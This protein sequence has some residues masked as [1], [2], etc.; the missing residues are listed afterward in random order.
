M[1]DNCDNSPTIT[2]SPAATTIITGS[3]EITIT[4]EDD[5]GNAASCTFFVNPNDVV[6]PTITCPV[7]QNVNVNSICQFT[8]PDYTGA[9][10]NDDC[11]PAP[12]VTQVP[13]IGSI[14]TAATTV[15]LTVTDASG[16]SD[17]CTF[18]AIP[19]DATAPVITC[20]GNQLEA[21]D[22][23]CEFDLINYTSLPTVNDNCD[24]SPVVTQSPAVGF[25]IT[26]SQVVTLTATDANGNASS[27]TF[28]VIPDDTTDPVVTCP[29]D[30]PVSF[31]AQCLYNII[32]YT[33]SAT[34]TDNCDNSLTL[35]QSPVAGTSV[36]TTTIVEI[37]AT[38]DDGNS[39]SCTF[40]VI[41][42]DN[43][44]P[45]I[46][47]PGDQVVN[48]NAS[49]QYTLLNYTSSV[50]TNDNCDNTPTVTQSP[51][52][53]S[54]ITGATTITMTSTDD[55]GNAASC[56]FQV[57]PQDVTNPTISCGPNLTPSFNG[58]CQFTLGNYLGTVTA[59]DN[60]DNS[61][62]ITQ[63]PTLG[64]VVTGATTV[65]MTATDDNS[66][67]ASCTFSINPVDGQ[68]PSV[69]CPPT[70]NVSYS[71][72]CDFTLAD[73]TG[74][75]TISDN[76]DLTPTVTQSPSFGTVITN[77]QIVTITAVDDAGNSNNCTFSVI[78]AD[79]TLPTIT[80]PATQNVSFSA[81]C[82]FTLPNY[83]G[84]APASDNCDN[85][86]TVTQ[87][88]AA[89][90][91]IT[92]AQTVTL[93]ATDNNSNVR[94]CTF[95][96]IPTDNTDPTISCG[97]NLSVNF[98][99]SCQFT[100]PDYT[101]TATAADNCTGSPAVS[102][103]PNVGTVIS[104]STPIVLTATDG[105]GNTAN[106]T[107]T[108]NPIDNEDPTIT[109]PGNQNVNFDVNCERALADYTGQATAADNCDVN[110]VITQSPSFGSVIT[111]P[112][113]VTITATDDA[114]NFGTCTLTVTPEDN[115][116]PTITCPVNQSENFSASCDFTLPDYTGLA[117]TADNCDTSVDVTQSP[118]ATTT[119]SGAQL[120]TLTATDDDGNTSSCT[121]SVL[122]DDTTDPT[123]TCPGD[124]NVSSNAQ[125]QFSIV[126]YTSLGTAADNCDSNP[127]ITQ[128][129]VSG[130][131]VGTATTVTLTA[132]D[133]NGN[134]GSCT[135]DVI[136]A[137][138]TNPTIACP[139]DQNVSFDASC[140]Y[141]L[142]NYV[143]LANANDNCDPSPTIT[144]SP[145]ATTTITTTQLVTLTVTDAAGN[146]GTCTF[147]VVP[148]D[149]TNPTITCPA[150]LDVSF[151]ASC[152]FTLTSYTG[153]ATAADNCD[154]TPSVTQSPASGTV[155]TGQ[156][157]ITLTATD[158]AGNLSTCTFDVIPDDD[159]N[160]T[161]T[162]PADQ[163]ISSNIDCDVVIPDYTSSASASDNCDLSL[164]LSQSPGSGTIIT[165]PTTVTITA[166]DD[167]G[168]FANCSFLVTPDD[169]DEPSIT[170]PGDQL[171][172]FDADCEFDI[173]DYT[174]LGT[175][176]DNCSNAPVITQ[177]V[178]VGTTITGQTT[179]VLTATD[180]DL[181][182]ATCSFEVIPDDNTAPSVTCPSN[183]NESVGN[184]C[185]LV[186]P[187][188]LS[189]VATD[190]NCDLAPV[191]AQ[192]PVA[193]SLVGGTTVVTVTSTD[194]A[195]N[196]GVCTFSVI[197]ADNTAPFLACPSDI[198]E[199]F[200][201]ACSFT[202]PNY[203]SLAT[204][205]DNC[206]A[207]P[208]TITQSPVATTAITGQT[209][210]TFS[211]TDGGG[212]NS[213]CTFE[214]IPDDDEDPTIVCPADQT[215][216]FDGNCQF[217]LADYTSSATV[218]DNCTVS[219]AVSQ[220]PNAGSV[221]T[222]NTSVALTVT[223]DAGNTAT[224]SFNV[225]PVD[226]T[227]P[228]VTCPVDQNV[229][230]SASCEFA[231]LDYTSLSTYADNCDNTPFA[232]QSPGTGTVISGQT[233]VTITITDDAGNTNSCDFDVIPEDDTNPTITCPPS[234][235]VSLS[236]TCEFTLPDYTAA[237]VVNDNCDT[238]LDYEQIPA[239]G[240]VISSATT[241]SV[242]IEVS[243]DAEN[244]AICFFTVTTE[245][246]TDPTLVCPANQ[247]VDFDA[248]CQFTLLDYVPSAT[249]SDN[250][251]ASPTVVQS[252]AATSTLSATTLVSI[253][254]TDAS[255]NESVCSFN[256]TP[257]DNTNP[258]IT[259]PG[260]QIVNFTS[261]C[262][263]T[264]P[265]YTGLSTF[266]DNCDNT[267][268]VTQ[269]PGTGTIVSGATVVTI[270]VLDDAGNSNDCTFNV[271]PNDVQNP[272]LVCPSDI[273]VALS[274]S[275][276]YTVGDYTSLVT[277]TD[278]CDTNV[279]LVQSP[280]SG[281]TVGSTT[282]ISITGTDDAG[283]SASCDFELVLED[284]TDPTITCPP[285][286][287]V[288]VGPSCQFTMVS[289][290]GLSSSADNCDPTLSVT[291][292]PLAGSS[293]GGSTVVTLSAQDDAGNIG[294]CTFNVIPADNQAPN[295]FGC[296]ADITVSNDAG[297]CDA[298]VTY[299]AIT[300]TDNC[301]GVVVPVLT[302]GQ[303]SGTIFALGTLT[304]TYVATDL[305]GN[306]TTCEFDVTVVDNEDPI[307]SCP[308]SQ[309]LNVD[310]STC[311][312]VVN[313]TAPT[314][315]DNCAS[316]VTP[317]LSAGL[318][319]GSTFP[320]GTT[321]VTFIANDGNGNDSS[322]SFTITVV[323]NEN[324]VITC[325]SNI[326]A[327]TGANSCNAFVNYSLPTVTDNCATGIV[328]VL[329]AGQNS[330]SS[331]ALGTTTV[332]YQANDGNGNSATC[333]FTITVEDNVDPQI[334]ACPL[335]IT[336][337]VEAG[338]CGATIVYAAVNATDNCAGAIT[339]TL[340]SGQASGTVF[341]LHTTTVTY[342]AD[343]GNGNTS[344]C[345]FTVTII[346]NELPV[347]TCPADITITA[348]PTLC[349][350]VV[351]YTLPTVTDNCTSPI[352]PT[353][354]GGLA[355]GSSFPVGTTTVTYGVDDGNGNTAS[356]SFDVTVTDDEIPTI[357]CP[358]S[359]TVD[360]DPGICGAVVTY[361]LPT[362]TDNCT[363]GIVPTLTL[364]LPSG[365]TFPVGTTP[366]RYQA[367]DASGNMNICSFSVTV[368]D[369]EVPALT[370]P[371]DIT[372]V[373]DPTV[374]Q[375]VVTYAAVTVTDNCTSGITPVLVAGLSS[376][377]PF[378]E[379]TTTV[380]YEATD[381]YGNSNSCSFD[382]TVDDNEVPT[383]TCPADFTESFNAQCQ[384]VIPDYTNLGVTADNCDGAPVV[385]QTPAPAST[386]T[387]AT[388]V[389]LTS[390]DVSGNENTC[391]FTITD[392]TPPTANCP[393]DQQ[394][395]FNISCSFVLP[396]YS[397]QVT[398]A[399]N[400]G[401]I[402][403]TQSPAIGTAITGQ[404]TITITVEDDFGNTST[405][406]FEVIPIDNIAP[407]IT[408]LGNQGVFV[409]ATCQF[410]LPDY[411]SQATAMD[412]C[413]TDVDITQSPSSGTFIGAVTAITLTATDD[414][415]N[416]VTCSFT[417]TPIDN[418]APSID[419]PADQ[420]ENFDQNCAFTLVDYT[421]LAST[422]DN[423]TA[424]AVVQ[425]P[426][427]GTAI[428]GNT[429]V[430]LT[431][432]D[433]NGNTSNCTFVVLPEDV[434]PPVVTC[435]ADMAVDLDENCEYIVVSH[436]SEVLGTD[437]CSSLFVY[438]QTPS[439]GT[440]IT[441]TTVVTATLVDASGNSSSCSFTID[442]TDNTPAEI[443]CGPD[444]IV[445]YDENCEFEIGDYSG[446]G[447]AIDN[448][449]SNIV[450]TQ[451]PAAGTVV[452]STSTV[453]LTANDGNGNI[454]TCT[455]EVT[456]EDQEPP[457]ITCI[458][459]Q[460]VSLDSNCEFVL[461][462][463]TV[464]AVVDDNCSTTLT[465]SQGLIS[466][467]SGLGGQPGNT[468]TQT[469]T[470]FL[471]VSDGNGNAA[472][473]TFDVIP[474]DDTDPVVN[475]PPDQEASFNSDCE[476]IL[477]DY[478]TLASGGD[479][480]GIQS[481]AQNPVSGTLITGATEVT[482]TV[483]DLSGNS[484][485]CSFMVEPVDE[486]APSITCP[487]NQTVSVDGNCQFEMVDYGSQAVVSD[488]CGTNVT[489]SQFPPAGTVIL[490]N[491]T[492]T[493]TADDGNGNT[494]G[495][496]FAV[497]P[498]DVTD[499]QII[500]C[501]P[502]QQITLDANCASVMPSYTS[503]VSA[504]D[505]CDIS[506]QVS[507]IP[508]QGTSIVGPGTQAVTISVQDDA[509]N[510]AECTF[511]VEVIDD[512][513][514]S[515]TCPVDQAL[516]LNSNCE[517]V[518]PDYTVLAS[519]TDA[520]GPVSFS[521]SPVAGSVITSQLNATII[522][523]DESGNSSTCT[524]FVSPQLM[525]VTATGTPV[526]CQGGS[527]GSAEVTVA[528][529]T[530]PYS[531]D[532][533]GFDPNALSWGTYSVTVTDANGC[534][535]T[536]IVVIEDGTLFEIE[537][538]PSGLVQICEGE[539]VVLDAGS[540]YAVYAWSTGASVQTI[541]VSLEA[542]YW[543]QVT[544]AVGCL[545]NVD[546]IIVQHVNQ[547]PP[548]ILELS[549]GI[550]SCSNDSAISYQW[551]LNGS[552]I[553]NATN[554]TYCPLASG[555]YSVQ[556][557]DVYGC[558]VESY[559]LEYTFDDS[560]PCATGIHEHDLSFEIYPNPSTGI[561]VMDFAMKQRERLEIVVFNILGEQITRSMKLNEQS[562]RETLDLS[563]HPTGVY[564]VRIV[565]DGDRVY[566][567]RIVVER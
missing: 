148:A 453:T 449:S 17:F 10:V 67:S 156:T 5:E 226:D 554:V 500:A 499:P 149:N 13:S 416:A 121:F 162:C 383:I 64:T 543:V 119:I 207:A 168:N 313:Y 198:T 43:A 529:G 510:V 482:L 37:T 436:E 546:T 30:L 83:T 304:V 545:S 519:S 363:S 90:T 539:S 116:N 192:S 158:A 464:N 553:Q 14:L 531:E 270:T 485:S 337:N 566:Q 376:G 523:Q 437:N 308:S 355:S 450:I 155:I 70:Q 322:C 48:A 469:E 538:N 346:D 323:D 394:V 388:V 379:G 439:V 421:G 117:L 392:D 432:T 431:A 217:S 505:N 326:T 55:D 387:G 475:C 303:A 384:L 551:Y 34:A 177:D 407:S 282:T 399:D 477:L 74:S 174:S 126:N 59:A 8:L 364:G 441:S 447:T 206:D 20:P 300:S 517:F 84:L 347:I 4:A 185:Q 239:A 351:T 237:A 328:P 488:N 467:P 242:S 528:G 63:S 526:T 445:A 27:C 564:I 153:S 292:S 266:D 311:G 240:T 456:G 152:Q 527:D 501:A 114:G 31:N 80:C 536:D 310:P 214:V 550:I 7:D 408:C 143:G 179:I 331:F 257:E 530:A 567:E 425:S 232:T 541:T 448:C 208:F 132:T 222:I 26:G 25:T 345:S 522:V 107:F 473:C 483:V 289:Y 184:Q 166:T 361:N 506:L 324:P 213:Q 317:T 108:I 128:S 332:S 16:N 396:D 12:A 1:A 426:I 532:W 178:S 537:A 397:L 68:V 51:A 281:N 85:S 182:T 75:A 401:G 438:S 268:F 50:V 201:A 46:S 365:D 215:V 374:C 288:S 435:P 21:F 56:S 533:G 176:T 93:T 305:A 440:V 357:T 457:T 291:Q 231:L 327:N 273:T 218:D 468:I 285:D 275:C 503:L 99:A 298:V 250:C 9:A 197:P 194:A 110:P 259:C 35:T 390:T 514:P 144:Q 434:T 23:D 372:T 161:I 150:D 209:T 267:P 171:E 549:D 419:C 211:V 350:A 24:A 284:Q 105:A 251:D 309:I 193:G 330:G 493:L 542:T 92:T 146:T 395:G 486:E 302:T 400:C 356:C 359:V 279:D 489:V 336:A 320:L 521:Q 492:V 520:C 2:Q 137:D 98:D 398:A 274:P 470:L 301:D 88:P 87:S 138:N 341:P 429:V 203:T 180:G 443:V 454:S 256:V 410:E 77:T 245:D 283:N 555:N 189:L 507:Q 91:V 45:S 315:T 496:Q 458:G 223:D 358:P 271:N 321:T 338:T 39:G 512:T 60:C 187:D 466:N 562:G 238:S 544:N 371:A 412:N 276:D 354:D 349:E 157:E 380:T 340:T 244:S 404:E 89:A 66:N 472:S 563:A 515:L 164:A 362:V 38:D 133:A 258:T 402:S 263:F 269:S 446:F 314:A 3:T 73:Y 411:T 474:T 167:N 405:C 417:V 163:I 260:D 334:L 228:T 375:A 418:T 329:T 169:D 294:T 547:E 29:A 444:Q 254:V 104:G 154:A 112:T 480:C 170:C 130:T 159:V 160:P 295:V 403:I 151:N 335:D 190:D 524:F 111:G 15:T 86:V 219:P 498:Q 61:L 173:I 342:V 145:V 261:N 82:N 433:D 348:E 224:C 249:I 221:Q 41:P 40:N 115:S 135:F 385:T 352:T 141:D 344:T 430:S 293:I 442:P 246:S 367:V 353:L 451:S 188:Y 52:A 540:G 247:T 278:N 11:D 18:S 95:S 386:V 463:Y 248:N 233:T 516:D 57:I 127:V 415:G 494:A 319:S 100:L 561:F 511:D 103:S 504:S 199:S 360:N 106:C 378:P 471:T 290:I 32:N 101:G 204:V 230:F 71:A 461:P 558:V 122:P 265:D 175:A 196:I 406:D 113:T 306:S 147:N 79:N 123:I 455:F 202:L 181:N 325:P 272:V 253:T 134:T 490:S 229:T 296:P 518:M 495:C 225:I 534:S 312:A 497:I 318:A 210:V 65:T 299:A 478:T 548:N 513:A 53:A 125:C 479:N 413:D 44:A 42:S 368:N 47:C 277:A 216:S 109:C 414:E 509:G 389:T 142:L 370:C 366:I 94:T 241:T 525:E 183:Q 212:N 36:G 264:L 565:L 422:D 286:Q 200:D 234:V 465:V 423:C 491:S 252:P 243:D 508:G 369:V 476:F 76:C 409:D 262:E 78:P 556:I 559:S 343:D 118:I 393:A 484:A 131:S 255:G 227:N 120:V 124:Q 220:L 452:S 6:D 69:T 72:T 54:T 307:L 557:L 552:P 560:S 19:N 195:G 424:V 339:P 136:P 129:P 381:A 191:V 280:A 460:Q 165:V 172:D 205:S 97:G 81:S 481:V 391:T 420:A 462:D 377:D 535:A 459:D 287:N 140:E 49:C 58:S 96:V 382:V 487:Q 373:T 316:P 62:T 22:A 297:S 427:A 102:Q 33:G 28:S 428:T 235:T 502:D 186:M 139:G 333:S 236:S